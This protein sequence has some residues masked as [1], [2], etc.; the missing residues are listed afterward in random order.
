MEGKRISGQEMELLKSGLVVYNLILRPSMFSNSKTNSIRELVKSFYGYGIAVPKVYVLPYRYRYNHKIVEGGYFRRLSH[1]KNCKSYKKLRKENNLRGHIELCVLSNYDLSYLV[2]GIKPLDLLGNYCIDDKLKYKTS[3]YEP[4]QTDVFVFCKNEKDNYCDTFN[5]VQQK[6]KKRMELYNKIG[7]RTMIK[8]HL[9]H[10]K[11][12]IGYSLMRLKQLNSSINLEKCVSDIIK[13][14]SL[15]NVKMKEF[16]KIYN[17][18]KIQHF[19]GL[20]CCWG[21]MDTDNML[22]RLRY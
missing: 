22:F 18:S 2:G 8:K 20:D 13:N 5:F 1:D 12:V 16:G 19:M 14:H 4:I 11:R 3:T 10:H 21:L 17:K 6:M 9:E 7:K 15:E